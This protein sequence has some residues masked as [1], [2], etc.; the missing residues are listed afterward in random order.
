MII[1][2][3]QLKGSKSAAGAF[4]GQLTIAAALASALEASVGDFSLAEGIETQV[5]ETQTA[6]KQ[7]A[8]SGAFGLKKT[9]PAPSHRATAAAKTCL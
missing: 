3:C 7:L 5:L 2:C 9:T 8:Q 4:C 1:S 6:E